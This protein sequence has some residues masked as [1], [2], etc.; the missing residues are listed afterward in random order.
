MR[1]AL[2]SAAWLARAGKVACSVRANAARGRDAERAREDG[3]PVLVDRRQRTIARP[4]IRNAA[5][6]ALS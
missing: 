1:S 5:A 4:Q 2:S 3:A 6:A